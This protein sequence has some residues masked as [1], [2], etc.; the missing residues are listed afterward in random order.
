LEREPNARYRSAGHLAEDLERWLEGR[1]IIAR[2][3]SPAMRTLRWS[4][5]NPKLASSVAAAVVLGTIGVIAAF[6]S[7]RLSSAVQN[8][9]LARHSIVV[10]PFE[11]LDDVSNT[12]PSSKAVA[13][14]FAAAL[15]QTK[16][17]RATSLSQKMEDVDPWS[18]EDWKKTGE[19]AGARFVLS[20]SV[21][22]REGK[23]RVAIHLIETTSGSVVSTWLQ[24][25][26][27]VADGVPASVMKVS[28]LLGVTKTSSAP[29][30]DPLVGTDGDV[31]AIGGSDNSSARSY[32]ERGKEFFLRQNFPDLDRAIDSLRTAVRLDS[33]YAQA[34]AL[35]ATACQL[36]SLIDPG[37]TWLDEADA[38]VAKALSIAPLLAEAYDARAGNSLYRGRARESLDDFLSA[39]ELDPANGRACSRLAYAY[40]LL[41][42][43]D[44]AM[45]W[46]AKASRRE[47][48]PIYADNIGDVWTDLG[49]YSKAEEAYN[50]AAIF[51]PDLPASAIGLS[52]VELCRGEFDKARARCQQACEKYKGNLQTLMMAAQIEFFSRNFDRAEKL[53]S[54]VM[55]AD[56]AGGVNYHGSVRF[57][58]AIGFIHTRMSVADGKPLLHQALTLDEK[59]LQ[60]APDNPAR[61]YSSAANYA[62]LDERASSL[63][64]LESAI[65]AGWIDY[66]SM[67]LDPRF[68]AVRNTPRFQQVIAHLQ[69]ATRDMAERTSKSPIGSF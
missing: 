16:G 41:G 68:D 47:T 37:G 64:A 44:R 59:E 30:A 60:A 65:Q 24:D 10:T 42:R 20:G 31:N 23:Q 38:A 56:H 19:S 33:N 8:A 48:K 1:P 69:Q 50:T 5:R 26:D 55:K 34:H 35:L 54:E 21:R 52:R 27:S 4:K 57:L 66:R 3:V 15:T 7:S 58:S 17:I 63:K 61:L 11:D 18:V 29:L 25:I 2:P 28:T 36:R 9:E 14:A 46:Y 39:Y 67:T 22:Q 40:H 32:Y 62:A 6:T 13:N 53:Y 12:S 43:L 51:R 49:E 45:V